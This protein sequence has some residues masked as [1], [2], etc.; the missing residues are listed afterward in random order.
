MG[1][2][3]GLGYGSATMTDTRRT[4]PGRLIVVP[5]PIGNLED[6]TYRAVRVLGEADAIACEDTRH[7][8]GVLEHYGIRR[9]LVAYHE[10]N[11]RMMTPRLLERL[12]AGERIALLT[13]AGMPGVS[14]PGYRIVAAAREAGV[15]V[16][17]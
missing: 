12:A 15:A 1:A 16:E 2:R 11:E 3:A 17:V 14:D 13:D 4:E 5:T 7:S 6:F 10:H 8:R 9:P